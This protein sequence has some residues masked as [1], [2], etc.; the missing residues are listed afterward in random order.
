MNEI[1]ALGVIGRVLAF[2][3]AVI[4][5]VPGGCFLLFGI[6]LHD[7]QSIGL[8]MLALAGASLLVWVTFRKRR[9]PQLPIPPRPRLF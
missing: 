5:L 4:L 7:A 6:G 2:V 3:L 1:G 8:G 9:P